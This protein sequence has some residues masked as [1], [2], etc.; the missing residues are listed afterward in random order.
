MLDR[1]STESAAISARDTATSD[2]T[3]DARVR[4]LLDEVGLRVPP[5]Q[6]A[7]IVG[8]DP[9]LGYRFPVGEAAAVALA[10]G[11]VAASDL[12]EL[13]TGRRQSVR[14]DVRKA[15]V[16]LRAT[17]VLKVNGGP[18]PP[19][20]ADGNP[21]VDLYQCRDGRWIHLHGNF[22]HL[23][24]GT[25]A[26]LGCSRDRQ[27]IA[28]AV[29]RRD[30]LEL[31]DALAGNRMCGA[32]ARTAEEWATHPQGQALADVPRVEIIKIGESEPV[33]LPGG[34][35]PLNGVRVL[36]LTRI[37]A[38]PT[39]ARTLAQYGADVLNI[40]APTLPTSDVWVM[41]TNQG[42][43]SAYLN[44]EQ[45][46]DLRRLQAL[47]SEADVFAQGF[48]A[49]ALERRGLGPAQVAALKPG[50]I[51]VSI[52]CY[53]HVGPW[54]GRPG[55]EQLA[56]TV[57]GLATAQ[58]TP[59]RPQRM[60]VAACDYTTGYLAALGTLVAVGRRAREGGSYHVRASLCQTGMWF[61]RLGA[62]CDPAQATGPGDTDHLTVES[63]TA[64]GRLRYLSPVV[65]LSETQPTW[66]R[67]PVPLGS[68]PPAWPA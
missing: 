5:S 44:L 60:P 20:W 6:A 53:G 4:A 27:E 15:A 36:D 58:G 63:D 67:P 57:T 56:Q 46:G 51:Y 29:A 22:P 52:N 30:A 38:G 17:L 3:M 64:W 59:E 26:V 32:M 47:I 8:R 19:S 37:L 13:Q 54:V 14:V 41:D 61:Q 23:A 9:I 16:S 33:P 7:T 35:S 42:K 24:A 12:W 10:A 55:W 25:M 43:L 62:T 34:D 50:I 48:R 11:G 66:T 21:L 68:H 65:E 18:P 1:M 45:A 2:Q 39:H 31:E 49:G 28:A 40:T